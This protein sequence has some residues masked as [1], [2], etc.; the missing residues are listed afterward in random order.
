MRVTHYVSSTESSNISIL[1]G[2]MFLFRRC[3]MY[4]KHYSNTFSAGF[5]IETNKTNMT[6]TKLEFSG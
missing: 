1:Y 3:K 5:F 2:V 4:G 6:M